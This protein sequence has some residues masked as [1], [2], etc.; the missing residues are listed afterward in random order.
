MKKLLIVLAVVAFGFVSCNKEKD[1]TCTTKSSVEE[2]AD[3]VVDTKIDGKEV[4]NCSDLNTEVTVA[5]ITT[6]MTC[7]E[8]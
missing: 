7:V 2:V 3:I 5:E 4:K 8:K 6:T 1:C